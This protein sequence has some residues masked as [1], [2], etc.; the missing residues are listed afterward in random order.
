MMADDR[1]KIFAG[2]AN[3]ELAGRIAAFLGRDLGKVTIEEFPDGETFVR[4]DENVRGEDVFIIQTTVAPAVHLLELLLMIDAAARASASRVTA[5]IP[6]FGYARQDRKDQPRV[7]I[8]AKLIANIIT[9]AGAD[10]VLT[11]DLHAGQI[12]GFFDIPLDNL[13]A[14]PVLAHYFLQKGVEDPVVLPPDLGGTRI[15]RDFARRLNAG[16]AVVEKRRLGSRDTQVSYL[17]GEVRGRNCI[18]VDDVLSTGGTLTDVA[19]QLQLEGA[20][21]IY[22]AV[23]HGLFAESAVQKLMDSPIE[24]IVVTDTVPFIARG[25]ETKL[26]VLSVA[27]LLGETIR[28]IHLGESVSSLFE[29]VPTG[30][31]DLRPVQPVQR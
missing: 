15:A 16:L 1:L 30:V 26:T 21:H 7:S 19:R 9:V 23:T 22:A 24:E 8:A 14:R 20:K 13:Y 27:G 3:P 4:Y 29:K 6:Y 12:Q 2:R 28:R 11:M 31:V 17:I 5:V 25:L 10:R 18:I